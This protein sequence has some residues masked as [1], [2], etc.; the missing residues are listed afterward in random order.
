MQTALITGGGGGMGLATAKIL[1]RDHRIVLAD[2]NQSRLDTA[3]AEL[4]TLG[5]EAEAAVCDITDRAAVNALVARANAQGTLRAVVHT[6]GVSPMMGSPEFIVRIN[7]LGTVNIVNAAL[8]VATEGFAVVNVASLAAHTAPKILI[9]KRTNRLAFTDPERL[10]TKLAAAAS[11]SPKG[12]R[13]GLAYS[14]SKAFV[15]WY[16]REMAGR[17]GAKGAR[18]LSVSPGSFDTEMGRLEIESGSER[19]LQF[20]ALR[21]FG[22]PTEIAELLAFCASDRCGYLTAVDILCDGGTKA[23]LTPKNMMKLARKPKP[24]V[25]RG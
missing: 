22:R 2:L 20:A 5:I 6:A 13:S 10:V 3:V 11:R 18:I 12:L 9:S 21:R 24:A 8:D 23:G 17:F 1:G 19:M 14:L 4:T 25:S 16:S 7:A 15:L